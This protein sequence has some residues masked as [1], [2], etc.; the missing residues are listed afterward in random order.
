MTAD[1][2]DEAAAAPHVMSQSRTQTGVR[3]AAGENQLDLVD[4]ANG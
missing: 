3:C 1:R 4:P 2:P